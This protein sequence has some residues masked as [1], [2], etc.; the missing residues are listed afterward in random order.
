MSD[1][2]AA[3]CNRNTDDLAWPACGKPLV[4][5]WKISRSPGFSKNQLAGGNQD[6]VSH[7]LRRA[8]ENSCFAARAPGL[9][10]AWVGECP[11]GISSEF[12]TALVSIRRHTTTTTDFSL[13]KDQER[14]GP[15]FDKQVALFSIV[16]V[17]AS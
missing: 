9:W 6:A 8:V 11:P 15:V 16:K 3:C 13:E 7:R 2:S 4:S 14:S 10:D 5:K 12:T 17:H 1:R